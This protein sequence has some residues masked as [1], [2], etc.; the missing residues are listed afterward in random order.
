MISETVRLDEFV[1]RKY[2]ERRAEHKRQRGHVKETEKSSG[3]GSR[4]LRAMSLGVK[5]SKERLFGPYRRSLMPYPLRLQ[6]AF[7]VF[8]F[9]YKF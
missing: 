4:V 8:H 9:L 6:S 7:T 2:R 5:C 3:T 1:E